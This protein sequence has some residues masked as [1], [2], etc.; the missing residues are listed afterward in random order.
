MYSGTLPHVI[1]YWLLGAGI[2]LGYFKEDLQIFNKLFDRKRIFLLAISLIIV[3]VNNALYS[4]MAES[5]EREFDA[6]SLAV[7]A[8]ANGICETFIF[9]ASFKLGGFWMGKHTKDSRWIYA[10]GFS[11]LWIYCG[12]IHA[13]FWI[14]ILPAHLSDATGALVLRQYF[15]IPVQTL[16]LASWSLIYYCYRDFWGV[17]ALHALVD[18]G[19]VCTTHY[20]LFS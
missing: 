15:F 12:A 11:L 19:F 3:L 16:N 10:A 18:A 7:F 20:S 1:I 4:R 6:L 14:N 8:I 17:A 2:G 9:L 5:G 13:L